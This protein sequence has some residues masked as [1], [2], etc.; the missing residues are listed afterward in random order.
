MN[1]ASEFVFNKNY[2]NVEGWIPMK[3]F[4]A[5]MLSLVLLTVSFAA[6][7]ANSKTTNDVAQ[8]APKTQTE[9]NEALVIK[10][11]DPSE[12][13]NAFFEKMTSGDPETL[14]EGAKAEELAAAKGFKDEFELYHTVE[15]LIPEAFEAEGKTVR[16]SSVNVDFYSGFVYKML[17]IP[18]ALYTPLFAMARIAGWSAHRIEELV[19]GGKLIRP[20]YRVVAPKK[21][22]TP[23]SER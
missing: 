9:T 17:N 20:A 8:V 23:M 11:V 5:L 4:I 18:T 22:Y 7:A 1:D 3:K 2:Y 15:R 21:P 13:E 6:F 19:S 16:S 12:A 14:P 10:I